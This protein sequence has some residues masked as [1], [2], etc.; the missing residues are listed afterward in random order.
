MRTLL[1]AIC[2]SAVPGLAADIY[3]F[4]IS[5]AETVSGPGCVP[6]VTGWGYT[7]QN[8]SSSDWSVTTGLNAGT[9]LYATP[10]LIFD[11]PDLAPRASVT[12]P[13]DPITPAGLYQILW[14]QNAPTGFANSGAFTLTAQWWSGDPTNGGTLIGNAPSI[15]QPYSATL[16]P[17]PGSTEFVALAL[18][19]LGVPGIFRHVRRP[20][21]SRA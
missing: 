6:T 4:S 11:F 5:P 20:H 19:L 10:Q 14:N 7:L 3:T 13:Y 8:Q 18:L 16:T 1:L 2:L 12:V 15:S 17:K 9:F 21:V